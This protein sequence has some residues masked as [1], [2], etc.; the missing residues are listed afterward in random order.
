M[1]KSRDD[2]RIFFINPKQRGIIPLAPP[3][4]TRSMRR[5]LRH[6]PYRL[7]INR[8]FAHVV[9]GCRSRPETW[10]NPPI[11]Q[12]YLALHRLGFAHSIEA[13]DSTTPPRLVGGIFGIALAG[14]FF[15][16]SMFSRTPNASKLALLQL[17]ARLIYGG[18]TLFDVQF[19]TPHLKQFGARDISRSQ[20]QKHLVA[21]LEAHAHMPLNDGNNSNDSRGK[22][23]FLQLLHERTLMS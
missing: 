17:I 7:T 13:W 3:R 10:I 6:P 5:L 4:I 11:R 22:D 8:S 9:D 14:A 2:D 16:E 15:G 21:A 19:T 20:F 1:A 23:L 18:F 12:M